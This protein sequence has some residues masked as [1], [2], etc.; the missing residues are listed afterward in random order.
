MEEELICVFLSGEAETERQAKHI[1][2]R[3][4]N[5]P[6]VNLMTTKESQLFAVFI[7]PKEQRWWI[8]HVEKHPQETFKLKNIQLTFVDIVHYPTNLQLHLP[9]ELLNISPCGSN[10]GTCSSSDN[11]CCCPATI[12]YKG[13]KNPSY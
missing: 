6:Y 12:F 8:E 9:E 1:A 7:L 5:C 10:C 4:A 11:C 2:T 13:Q 3:Y